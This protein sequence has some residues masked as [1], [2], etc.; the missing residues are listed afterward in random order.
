MIAS[1]KKPYEALTINGE[2]DT[3]FGMEIEWD[4]DK[5]HCDIAVLGYVVKQQE[6]LRHKKKR[7]QHSPSKFTPPQ[8]EQKVQ[9]G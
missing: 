1:L 5:G 7:K 8:Y 4:Y 6:N 9:I 3:Y 2:G